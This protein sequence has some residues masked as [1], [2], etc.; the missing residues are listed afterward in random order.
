MPLPDFDPPLDT[1]IRAYVLALRNGGVETFESCDGSPGHAYH[2]PTVRFH[3]NQA[4]GYRAL[5]VALNC[6]LSVHE[7]RRVWCVVAG[8]L[9]GPCWE[10]I[11]DTAD[12]APE[13]EA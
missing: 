11:F 1:G 9:T 5:A 12:P 13:P 2:E 7:L 4:E 8:E 10:L 6:G 3:G